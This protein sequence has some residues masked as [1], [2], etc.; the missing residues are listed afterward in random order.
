METH[1]KRPAPNHSLS[2]IARA[3]LL[4]VVFRLSDLGRMR[5]DAMNLYAK[6]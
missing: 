3:A 6:A 2:S 5:M 1:T 4:K